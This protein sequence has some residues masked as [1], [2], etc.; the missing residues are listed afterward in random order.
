MLPERRFPRLCLWL[1][2]ALLPSAYAAP[3]D[4]AANPE[5]LATEDAGATLTTP[6]EPG[7]P[8]VKVLEFEAD[9]NIRADMT[10]QGTHGQRG[11][12]FPLPRSW[13]LTADPV[14]HIE[15]A[16]SAALLPHRSHLTVLVNGHPIGTERLDADSVS[17]GAF[18]V[19]LPRS[20]LQDYNTV[21]FSAVQ[22]Y[23]DDCEDPFD[24]ALWTRI[25]RRSTLSVPYRRRPIVDGLEAWPFPIIDGRGIGPVQ[26]TPVLAGAPTPE[27]TRAAGEVAL[28]LG[29][30]ASYRTVQV[31]P[32]VAR[33]E[34][35]RTAAIIVGSVA[36]TPAVEALLGPLTLSASDG[37]VAVV[38]NP[39]D[40]SLPILI[41]SG[42][43]PEGVARAAQALT[44]QDREPVLSGPWSVVRMVTAADPPP[45]TQNPRPAPREGK[46]PLAALGFKS[47]TVRGYFPDAIR[48]PV[49]LEGDTF[50]RPGGGDLKLR[51]A[52]SAQLDS[53]LAAMEVRLDGL[54]LRSV[55]LDRIEGREDG[56]LELRLPEELITPNS[57]LEVVFHL[58]PR[59]FDAC[60]HIADQQI[61]GTV[62]DMSTLEIPRDHIAD[63]PDLGRL[64]FDGWPLR[65][66][67][68]DGD[69]IT[70]LPDQPSAEAWAAGLE[71]AAMVGRM[72]LAD[73]PGFQLELASAISFSQNPNAH[74]VLLADQSKHTLYDS[75]AAGKVLAITEAESERTLNGPDAATLLAAQ[76]SL[77]IDSIEQIL[78]PA[79]SARST[80]VL[81]AGTTT[82]LAL[83]VDTLSDAGKVSLLE[84]NAVTVAADGSVRVLDTAR[85]HRWGTLP[86]ATEAQL[87]VRRYWGALGGALVAAALAIVL[88][89]RVWTESRKDE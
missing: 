3:P 76:G 84:G 44:G 14:L 54:S 37:I 1:L 7:D 41:V 85:R 13:E 63:M 28:A 52:Y 56:E 51:Y 26:L 48:I 81:H 27:T 87:G 22:H 10:L 89:V 40:P 18:D 6:R 53:A 71:L 65:A 47:H 59:E 80:L 68:A 2:P 31:A 58:F 16:H 29:R 82:G 8:E 21:V 33:L 30:L 70:V 62:F 60:K 74:F 72:S 11:V 78:H 66:D 35:A 46:F 12:D 67:A 20:L 45:N 23:T 4:P 24:P 39:S 88:V 83:L 15:F 69:V 79:N 32:A 61:W 19:R 43:G 42:G 86:M 50:I 77:A 64:R 49:R 9:L 55:P 5:A 73:N 17:D 36:E 75:L 38:P 25:A 34:N 57:R